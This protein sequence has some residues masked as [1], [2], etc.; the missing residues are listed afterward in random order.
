MASPSVGQVQIDLLLNSAAFQAQLQTAVNRAVTQ[1]STNIGGQ[2]SSTFARLGKLAVAAFSVRAITGFTKS[3]IELGSDLQEIQNVVDVAFP[4]MSN[5]VNEFAAGAIKNFGLSEAA[6]KKLVGTYGAMASSFGFTEEEALKMSTTLTGLAGDVASFYNISAD[7]AY[8]KLK[9]VFTGETETLKDL[10]VVM[11]QTALD[12]FAL[13]KGFGKTTKNMSQQEKV[14]LRYAFVQD[15]LAKASGDFIRT[16]D[17]WAN[18]TRVLSLQWQAFKANM[19]Q[20]FISLLTP[21]I[22]SLNTVME[23]LVHLSAVFKALME[24]LYGKQEAS[25]GSGI[26]EVASEMSTLEDN[27]DGVG[28]AATSAAKKLK[29]LMG[30]DNLNVLADNSSSGIDTSNISG[31]AFDISGFDLD[32]ASIFTEEIQISQEEIDKLKNALD[33]ILSLVTLIGGAFAGWKIAGLLSS[34]KPIADLMTGGGAGLF[35]LGA[36]LSLGGLALE[37]KALMDAWGNGF[38]VKNT[39]ETVLGG[40]ALAGGAAIIGKV[41]GSTVIGAA[42][43]G[44]VAGIPAYIVGIK[45]ALMN[46]L[47][48][49][50]GIII[51]AGATAAGAGIGAIIGSLGGPIGAGIGALIGLAI[52]LLTDFG[53][54]IYQNW[55]E[56]SAWFTNTWNNLNKWFKETLVKAIIW[57]VEFTEK[58]KQKWEEVKQVFSIIWDLL[59]IKAQEKWLEISG[60]FTGQFESFKQKFIDIFEQVKEKVTNTFSSIKNTIK[61]YVN[62]VIEMINKLIDGINALS[63]DFD[64]PEWVPKVGGKTIGFPKINKLPMLAEGGYVGPNTPQLAMIGDNRHSGEIIAPE[65]KL[66]AIVDAKTQPILAAIYQLASVIA[67]NQ[68]NGNDDKTIVINIDGTRLDEFVLGSNNRKALR[69]GGLA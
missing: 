31:S 69:S 41:F 38:D 46:G 45:D 16:Q 63:L 22:K 53:I 43:G 15:Q 35:G 60:W 58:F 49:L 55:G 24:Q 9:S 64:V 19:G 54:W 37:I 1:T 67:Q 4:S 10:G 44:I 50:N 36:G 30:F 56:I 59:K 25:Q 23:K 3:C 14:A 42:V 7:L 17:G 5:K 62:S 8:T 52:G 32:D 26:T 18:Q 20:G 51:P 6:A 34:I 33:G 65:D 40:G 61:P 21:V 27:T 2:V 11:T 39:L 66:N 28:K 57:L 12:Q 68:N 47:N 13:E 48:W 29:N